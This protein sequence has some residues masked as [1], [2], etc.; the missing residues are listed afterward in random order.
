MQALQIQYREKKE[1]GILGPTLRKCWEI[2]VDG[3]K[4]WVSKLSYSW[5]SFLVGDGKKYQ[6]IGTPEVVEIPGSVVRQA[7][8]ALRRD[9]AFQSFC[10]CCYCS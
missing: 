5:R 2:E 8:L 7:R 6:I 10:E 9:I 4:V 1:G 3:K